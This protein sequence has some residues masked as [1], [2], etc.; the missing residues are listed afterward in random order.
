MAVKYNQL[1]RE[2]QIELL[3]NRERQLEGEHLMAEMQ[4]R[5][6]EQ[7]DPRRFEDDE[8]KGGT[9]PLEDAERRVHVVEAEIDQVRIE[10]G[11]LGNTD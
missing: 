3:T 5:A 2:D 8:T 10:L 7:A 4:R 6:L 9:S 11:K 1:T